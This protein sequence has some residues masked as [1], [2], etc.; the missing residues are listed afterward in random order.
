MTLL[1]RED[2]EPPKWSTGKAT[3]SCSEGFLQ[4]QMQV[5][6]RKGR[7][8]SGGSLSDPPSA[9]G[10]AVNRTDARGRGWYRHLPSPPPGSF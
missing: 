5:S 1:R 7:E 3:E 2:L 9:A 8:Q 4:Y 6:I 10:L